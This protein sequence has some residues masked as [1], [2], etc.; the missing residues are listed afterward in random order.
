MYVG[1]H[2]CRCDREMKSIEPAIG[3]CNEVKAVGNC[4]NN[5]ERY[6]YNVVEDKCEKFMYSGCNGN[7]NNFKTLQE[8]AEKCQ[9]NQDSQPTIQRASLGEPGE[10]DAIKC[11]IWLILI[12]M[13]LTKLHS[14]LSTHSKIL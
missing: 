2:V 3:V 1:C 12:T 8:C 7:N 6:Y 11:N 13:I 4:N 9:V 10:S 5:I 14:I